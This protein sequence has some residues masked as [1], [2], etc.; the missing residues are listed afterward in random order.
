ML[1]LILITISLM[2]WMYYKLLN[3][4]TIKNLKDVFKSFFIEPYED[5]MITMCNSDYWKLKTEMIFAKDIEEL[6]G[7]YYDLLL[8]ETKF[9]DAVPPKMVEEKYNDL[10]RIFQKLIFKFQN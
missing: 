6:K 9:Q 7:I 4:E 3:K 2:I 1:I 8:F 5:E 10:L